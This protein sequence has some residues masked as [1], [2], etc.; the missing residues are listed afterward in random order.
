MDKNKIAENITSYIYILSIKI[1]NLIRK[2][3]I[4]LQL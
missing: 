3:I 4:T 2:S 1:I